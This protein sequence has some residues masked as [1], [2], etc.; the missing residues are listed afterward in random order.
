MEPV[1][2]PGKRAGSL[3]P[4]VVGQRVVIRRLLPGQT[5]PTGGPA[6]TDVLG[7]CV[8]WADGTAVIL[9]EDGTRVSIATSEIV[10]GK[11][12]PPRPPVRH[13]VTTREAESHAAPLW[14]RVDRTPLG[15]W[16]LRF[17]PAPVGRPRKRA[18]SCLAIGDPGVPIDR[19]AA[20]VVAHY[21]ERDRPAL[22]QVE[23]DS[24]VDRALTDLGWTPVSGDAALLLGSL[25]RARR[26][27]PHN[28]LPVTVTVTYDDPRAQ[29]RYLIGESVIG[30]AEAAYDGDWLG[31]HSLEVNEAHR[32][33]GIGN[34]LLAELIDFGAER[35]CLTLWLHVE[36]DNAPALAMYEALGLEVHHTCRYLTAPA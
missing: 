36:L 31:V 18:N 2:D 13:R 7:I 28:D 6:F 14:P 1:P 24:G 35:G 25:A 20:A 23:A 30:S 10:S 9:R 22:V 21:R 17:D 33:Q 15:E 4:G 3:G 32:R 16:E 29:S 11:P 27:L 19:A 5:G 26:L 34:A 12:V 8:S